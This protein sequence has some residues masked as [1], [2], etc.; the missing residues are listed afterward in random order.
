MMFSRPRH[1][2][3]LVELLVVI[4]II[5]VLVSLLLPAVQQAR[6]A[7]RRMQCTNNL[8]QL[9][10]ANHN[11]H[12][13]YNAFPLGGINLTGRNTGWGARILPFIEQKSLYDQMDVA[14]ASIKANAATN[15]DFRNELGASGVAGGAAVVLQAFMCPSDTGGDH[16]P[17]YQYAAKSN[18]PGNQI[19]FVANRS[20]R[21]R[22]ITDGLSNTLILSERHL[23]TNVRYPGTG[24]V[25]VFSYS[26]STIAGSIFNARNPINTPFEPSGVGYSSKN[27]VTENSALNW[28]TRAAVSSNHPGGAMGAMC[29][30]SVRFLSETMASTPVSPA[31]TAANDS[32][33]G[34]T[35]QNLANINDG[36]ILTEY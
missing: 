36:Y 20:L 2:F 8:K 11:Y 33:P 6:E 31:L 15:N 29:D 32:G 7:A 30:G 19:F 35:W 21:M 34:Y 24:A 5:G 13:T 9:A 22:D 12:D 26:C 10:L 16:N 1:A 3:T 18:Y 25:W 28:V 14:H 27:C 23:S 4:A 17:Y